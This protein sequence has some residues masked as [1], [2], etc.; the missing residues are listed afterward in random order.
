MVNGD[1][2]SAKGRRE[3]LISA[4]AP[5]LITIHHSPFTILHP[6]STLRQYPPPKEEPRRGLR[7]LGERGRVGRENS[8]SA[9]GNLVPRATDK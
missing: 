8:E 4:S 2:R 3:A 1:G 7:F 6:P 9:D 5:A